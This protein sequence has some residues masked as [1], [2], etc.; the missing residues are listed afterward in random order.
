[1]SIFKSFMGLFRRKRNKGD[2]DEL[3][4]TFTHAPESQLDPSVI[5]RIKDL[6]G[7]PAK[8]IKDPLLKIIDDCVRY[9]L[10]SSFTIT[11]LHVVWLNCGG[12]EQELKERKR[13]EI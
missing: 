7:K 10:A 1:M 6:I 9:S 4:E 12:T 13:D 2:F 5:P 3:L 8:D 11:T